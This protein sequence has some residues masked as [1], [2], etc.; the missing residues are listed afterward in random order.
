MLGEPERNVLV[1]AP[2][3][4]PNLL[5]LGVHL[6]LVVKI[7][8]KSAIHL[9]GSELW[10]IPEDLF[11]RQ[12]STVVDHHGTDREAGAL[13]DWTPAAYTPLLLD[14]GISRSFLLYWHGGLTSDAGVSS[15]LCFLQLL[16]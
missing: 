9:G 7:V 10:E 14:V 6:F 5:Y 8:G 1:H 11:S 15:W 12:P 3:L 13:N 2:L 16:G 4:E